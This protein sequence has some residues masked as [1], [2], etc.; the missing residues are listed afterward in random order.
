[1]LQY[2]KVHGWLNLQM[3]EN[4]GYRRLTISYMQI[5]NYEE[6]S[7]SNPCIVQEVT[8]WITDYY[9]VF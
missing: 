7:A 3:W 6:V 4:W 8:V 1:M 2:Y 9:F 5:F